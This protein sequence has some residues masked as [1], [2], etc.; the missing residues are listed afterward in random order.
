MTDR[1]ASDDTTDDRRRADPLRA[2]ARPSARQR[3]SIVASVA[4]IVAAYPEAT[5]ALLSDAVKR[6]PDEALRIVV[7]CIKAN[8]AGAAEVLR[9]VR[10]SPFLKAKITMDNLMGVLLPDLIDLERAERQAVAESVRSEPAQ[11]APAE[12]AQPLPAE[13][14]RP[15]HDRPE[16]PPRE[17]DRSAEPA[18]VKD[19]DAANS[20]PAETPPGDH[21]DENGVVGDDFTEPVVAALRRAREAALM[22]QQL[23]ETVAEHEG[24]DQALGVEPRP[25]LLNATP[26]PSAW[27]VL[28][29]AADDDSS[30]EPDEI[31]GGDDEDVDGDNTVLHLY[32]EFDEEETE[33]ETASE[34]VA[35]SPESDIEPSRPADVESA[36]AAQS[37][38]ERQVGSVL[39][40]PSEIEARS[41]PLT[42]A[43][44]KPATESE[45]EVGPAD[46]L[47]H[48]VGSEPAPTE[49]E[50]TE[51][52][53]DELGFAGYLSGGVPEGAPLL[54][55][56]A[57]DPLPGPSEKLMSEFADGAGEES[58]SEVATGPVAV[59]PREVTVITPSD[60]LRAL[61]AREMSHDVVQ[62]EGFPAG[63][64]VWGL[65][66]ED[67]NF[68]VV[69]RT[70][71]GEDRVV[72]R[73]DDIVRHPEALAEIELADRTLNLQD[74]IIGVDLF[75]P[76]GPEG[77]A[78][79]PS[80][81]P[82][83][84]DIIADI[85]AF[86]RAASDY[87]GRGDLD[88]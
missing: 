41:D 65:V 68:E 46:P 51:P 49:P 3:S 14:T 11:T 67:G 22:N 19:E 37:E 33:D 80:E 77:P 16:A 6:R 32:P 20:D 56:L 17:I 59:P 75:R 58:D 79:A 31:A 42:E 28:S 2:T 7:A 81:S 13:P 70:L 35:R 44:P 34:V 85:R 10:E 53:S 25:P 71:D 45:A 78:E 55:G 76:G 62:L 52:L 38:S 61:N 84:D 8:P 57:G 9:I 82:P 1:K 12:P 63:A 30:S 18:T 88:A 48:P 66:T 26:G 23:Q 29:V 60:G 5:E 4:E 15:P 73:I 43:P 54:F 87:R 36:V 21:D 83:D 50:I 69:L 64:S 86:E 40:P 72:A 39:E 27:E 47:E 24:D 74:L